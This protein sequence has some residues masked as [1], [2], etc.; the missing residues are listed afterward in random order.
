MSMVPATVNAYNLQSSN[1]ISFAAGILRMPYFH[2]DN[3]EY[4]NYGAMGA[5]AGHEIGHSFDNIGRR[6]DEIGGLKNWWTEATAEVFN[7]K[8]QCFVEQYG[9]FTIKGSDNKDYNLNGRLTLDENLADNGGLKM[10]F[11]AWQSLIKS[12]PDGQK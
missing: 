6:Y 4:M 3:P 5:I 12:D 9:N 1:S 7:E 8:A 11:S 10:S 2:V